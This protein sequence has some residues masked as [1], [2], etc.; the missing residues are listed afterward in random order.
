MKR[1]AVNWKRFA[2][3]MLVSV[4]ICT[5]ITIV[6]GVWMNGMPLTRVPK[7]ETVE[8][9]TILCGERRVELTDPED[10]ALMVNAANLL[11]YKPF[12]AAEDTPVL[13]VTYRQA[14]G[15][16]MTLEASGAS[17]WW[18]GKARA[19]QEPELFVNIVTTLFLDGPYGE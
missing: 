2:W 7:A 14:D 8:A 1:N 16:Q 5:V 3:N 4:L 18:K 19:L 9:V 17:V 10:V 11:N 13:S 15:A 6:G 12:R